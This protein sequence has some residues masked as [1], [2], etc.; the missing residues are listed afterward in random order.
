MH[1]VDYLMMVTGLSFR[2]AT[3]LLLV[4]RNQQMY[5]QKFWRTAY[6]LEDSPS[7][8]ALSEEAEAS[9]WGKGTLA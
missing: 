3:W 6:L 1:R 8:A 2:L 7:P 5:Q 4:T 9:T